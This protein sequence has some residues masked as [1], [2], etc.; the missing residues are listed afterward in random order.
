MQRIIITYVIT[1][2]GTPPLNKHLKWKYPEII[3]AEVL[4]HET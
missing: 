4:S 2:L 3:T 1:N